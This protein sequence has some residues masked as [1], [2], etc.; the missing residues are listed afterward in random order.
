MNELNFRLADELDVEHTYKWVDNIAS[1]NSQL[2]PCLLNFE[3]YKNEFLSELSDDSIVTLICEDENKQIGLIKI[4][5]NNDEIEIKYI[6]SPEYRL[7]NNYIR[8][9]ISIGLEY[10]EKNMCDI[11]K[12]I[13]KSVAEDVALHYYLRL[14]NFTKVGDIFVC[15]NP[16]KL[17]NKV[18]D[19][20][21]FP[22]VLYLTNNENAVGLFEWISEK[23]ESYIYSDKI[24]L[25]QVALLKPD[26]IIS[27]NYNFIITQDI[28]EYMSENIVNLHISYLPYNRGFSPNIWSFIDDTPKG[29]TI[30]KISCGLDEG[31]IIVQKEMF[32]DVT[33]ETLKTSYERLNEEIVELFKKNYNL[34]ID[35]KYKKR[36]QVGIGTKHTMK[37]L[38]ILQKDLN[39]SW[40][41]RIESVL[42]KYRQLYK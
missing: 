29:V 12:I 6:I 14:F 40:E 3:N 11:G 39:F 26:I 2:Y 30:H 31:D 36:K 27:Y 19:D 16:H 32:F 4:L 22:R 8:K 25:E 21:S 15:N 35:G 10:I 20:S 33:K 37:Q 41:D 5:L 23:S 9:M 17:T 18:V 24:W 42:E 1:R 7:V 13:V 28:I 38:E 34:I